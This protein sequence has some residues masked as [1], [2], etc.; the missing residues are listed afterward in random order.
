MRPWVPKV[1]EPDPDAFAPGASARKELETQQSPPARV[2]R[3]HSPRRSATI[4]WSSRVSPSE[5]AEEA[6]GSRR[7]F[8]LCAATY[9][10]SD[11][12]AC[13][14]LRG[15]SVEPDEHLPMRNSTKSIA[16]TT[17]Q[18]WPNVDL[19]CTG[20]VDVTFDVAGLADASW[21]S[22]GLSILTGFLNMVTPPGPRSTCRPQA[23]N[24][25]LFDLEQQ[26]AVRIEISGRSDSLRRDAH[27]GEG[28][29]PNG[30]S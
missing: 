10:G 3:A 6:S 20:F 7:Q 19:G 29:R 4:T 14:E 22:D 23:Q 13:A 12:A 28:S 11:T 26:V 16:T 18:P 17:P 2:T 5:T 21:R 30:G 15:A 24:A 1:G 25:E 8:R 9:A 27:L